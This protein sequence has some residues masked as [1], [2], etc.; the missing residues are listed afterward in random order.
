MRGTE[1]I[2][3]K[4]AEAG[5]GKSDFLAEDQQYIREELKRRDMVAFLA[6]GSVLPARAACLTGR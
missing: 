2:L 1:P 6:D 5:T 3:W 4:D